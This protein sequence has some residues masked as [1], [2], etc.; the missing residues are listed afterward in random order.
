MIKELGGD[1]VGDILKMREG[2][3]VKGLYLND[4]T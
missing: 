3:T 4:R 1:L 2:E